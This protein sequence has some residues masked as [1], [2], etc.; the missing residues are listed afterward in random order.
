MESS[1][2]DGMLA[3]LRLEKER[4]EA[5]IAALEGLKGNGTPAAPIFTE[6]SLRQ[7]ILLM[8]RSEPDKGFGMPEISARLGH[9][10]GHSLRHTLASSVSKK[11]I[12]RFKRG[13]YRIA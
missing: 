13:V 1:Q 2:V 6:G 10:K 5:A 12:K 11:E 3:Q 8:L 4:V 9:P 7:R